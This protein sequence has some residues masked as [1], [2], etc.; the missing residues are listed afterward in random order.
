M[1]RKF[2]RVIYYAA[3]RNEHVSIIFR[4]NCSEASFFTIKSQVIL[5]FTSRVSENCFLKLKK[6]QAVKLTR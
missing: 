4:V 3:P 2:C 6:E 1:R 5:K